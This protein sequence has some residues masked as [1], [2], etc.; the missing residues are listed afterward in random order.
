MGD[1]GSVDRNRG[2]RLIMRSVSTHSPALDWPT[3][4]AIAAIAIS[5]NVAFHEGVHALACIA[6]SGDLQEFSA[7]H[8]DCVTASAWQQKIVAGSASV[9]NLILGTLL[10][11]LLRRR[12]PV[13]AEGRFSLWLL[14]LMSWLY[15]AGYWMFSGAANA[16]DWAAVIAGLEPHWLW[17]LAI[18]LAGTALFVLFVWL[19]LR[20]LGR[21][22]GG[23]TPEQLRPAVRL[24]LA[25]Y[26][27]AGLVVLLA[28][29]FNP[30][31]LL[32][33]PAVYG[34]VA[35]LGALSPLLWMM[36]WFRSDSFPK[37]A[38]PPFVIERRWSLIALAGL[39]VFLYTV[40]LGRSLTF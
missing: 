24:G 20:E 19:A 2:F 22:F 8:V 16:G 21:F 18:F 15:G 38:A 13:S 34:F 32:G 33:G 40:V 29:L 5:L 27:T 14:M 4:I 9:A 7:L 30:H 17:R 6:I 35:A 36:L 37:L 1:P 39:A 12:P 11:L 28:G 23:G 31:G 26:F 10:W 3:V 25:A